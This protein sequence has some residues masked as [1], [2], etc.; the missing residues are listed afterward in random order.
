VQAQF[1]RQLPDIELVQG[2]RHECDRST[3]D[4]ACG[5]RPDAQFSGRLETLVSLE[6]GSQFPCGSPRSP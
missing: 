2:F 6:T 3:G 4:A 5:S 1:V